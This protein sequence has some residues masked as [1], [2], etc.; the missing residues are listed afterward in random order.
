MGLDRGQIIEHIRK[1]PPACVAGF[2]LSSTELPEPFDDNFKTVYRLACHCGCDQG[3]VLGYQLRDYKPTHVGPDLITPL[4]FKCRTCATVT[5]IID[6]DIHGYHAE[7][8]KLDGGIG[9]AKYRGSG[10]PVQFV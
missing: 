1:N 10:I 5:Q 4:S 8:G 9:S 2:R 6:T 7:V 3:A